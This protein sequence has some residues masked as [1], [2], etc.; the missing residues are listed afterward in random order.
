MNSLLSNWSIAREHFSYPFITAV[1]V[2]V[3]VVGGA[4]KLV[5]GEGVAQ[6]SSAPFPTST[7][8]APW[9][10]AAKKRKC[11]PWSPARTGRPYI[12]IYISVCVIVCVSVGDKLM[13]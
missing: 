2:S 8:K 7:G 6:A 12:Y 3:P 11:H 13:A 9:R 1:P 10:K 5:R 4:V